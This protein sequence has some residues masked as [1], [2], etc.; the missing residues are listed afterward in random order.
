MTKEDQYDHSGYEKRV[1]A[2][3]RVDLDRILERLDRYLSEKNNEAA[4]RHLDYWLRE[5]R[6][7]GDENGCFSLMN[8]FIGFYRKQGNKDQALLYVEKVRKICSASDLEGTT[9]EMT[10]LINCATAMTAFGKAEEAASLFEKAEN[11]ADTLLSASD[12]R[13]GGLFNNRGLCMEALGRRE[14]AL[15]NYEQALLILEQNPAS[16]GE[17]AITYLNMADTVRGMSE[18]AFG[19]VT[20]EAERH[21]DCLLEQASELLKDPNLKQDAAARY[22]FEKCAPIF[23]AYGWFMEEQELWKRAAAAE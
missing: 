17:R 19:E 11:L 18:E 10:S 16:Q 14:E 13:R 22:I 12:P 1:N 6:M 21:I 4:E 15:K 23:G 8:E 20:A 7:L 9:A 5:A 3:G 2:A